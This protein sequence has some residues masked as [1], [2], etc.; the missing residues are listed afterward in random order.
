MHPEE[1]KSYFS[2]Q[3]NSKI[4]RSNCHPMCKCISAIILEILKKKKQGAMTPQR[5][6]I[7]LTA[8]EPN[9]K[10]ISEQ[11]IEE[12]RKPAQIN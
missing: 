12:T 9:K 11:C 3:V 8:M 5:N 4:R 10:E 6:T 7:I 1:G 2:V